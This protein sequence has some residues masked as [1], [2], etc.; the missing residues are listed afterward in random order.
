MEIIPSRNEP[1]GEAPQLFA[2]IVVERPQR[3]A[4]K[5]ESL[6][7]VRSIRARLHRSGRDH[8][9]AEHRRVAWRQRVA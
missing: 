4:S 9:P 1:E 3:P 2:P 8:A 7:Y 6:A 5:A